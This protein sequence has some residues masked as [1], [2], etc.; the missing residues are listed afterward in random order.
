MKKLI[1]IRCIGDHS[2]GYGHFSRCLA[3]ARYFSKK[4]YSVVFLIN[5]NIYLKNELLKTKFNFYLVPQ[6]KKII[7]EGNFLK[8]FIFK[9]NISCL[10]ID[11]KEFSENLS[12]EIQN[13]NCLTAII[14]DSSVTTVYSDILLNGT[15][16]KQY[17][18]YKLNN[19]RSQ[20][21]LG[22]KYFLNNPEFPQFK[23]R[24]SEIKIKK[25]YK[26]VVSC[27]GSDVNNLTWKIVKEII[28]L[29]NLQI[30]VI[31]GPLMK[32]NTPLNIIK[33][34]V[35][36]INSPKKIWTIFNKSD[37]VICTSGSTLFELAIQ[38]IPCINIA[39]A[40]HQIAYGN[41]FSKS[42]F[43][44]YMGFWKQMNF[45]KFSSLLEECLF[46]SIKRKKM[47]SI[48]KKLIDGRGLERFEKVISI[49]IKQF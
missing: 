9:N 46:D 17:H 42:G 27:G 35:K 10:I 7:H 19:K 49:K 41:D 12:K 14:D 16:I 47:S 20:L 40:E 18:N 8:K 38:G 2:H 24:L 15:P 44:I 29:P 26:V 32:K 45:S 11:M 3:V 25:N 30:Q 31:I 6:F 1:A 21:L 13:C 36:I 28:N 43:G 23:K 4:N 34:N 37:L 39:T 22:S 33:N 48:G 5:E